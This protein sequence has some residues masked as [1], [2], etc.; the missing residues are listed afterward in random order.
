[1]Q[2]FSSVSFS[3]LEFEIAWAALAQASRLAGSGCIIRQHL[4]LACEVVPTPGVLGLR[5]ALASGSDDLDRD[6]SI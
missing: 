6:D 4:S 1:M 5:E 3:R 2:R